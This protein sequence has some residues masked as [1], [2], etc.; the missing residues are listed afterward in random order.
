MDNQ[1]ETLCVIVE[2]YG[3]GHYFHFY[4]GFCTK[5]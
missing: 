1:R 2:V 3:D 4:G 5:Q